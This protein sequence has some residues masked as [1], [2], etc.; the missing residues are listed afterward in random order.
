AH[1]RPPFATA[2]LQLNVAKHA[3]RP[4]LAQ[5]EP[6]PAPNHPPLLRRGCPWRTVCRTRDTVSTSP[7][8]TIV[9]GLHLR[10]NICC[11]VATCH[12]DIYSNHQSLSKVRR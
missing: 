3:P 7:G 12:R 8:E 10:A 6:R 4:H 11:H 2:S 9:L 5:Q 1:H